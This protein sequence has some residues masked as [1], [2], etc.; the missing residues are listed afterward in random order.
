MNGM[1]LPWQVGCFFVLMMGV[2]G[3]QRTAFGT[4]CSM[5]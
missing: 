4:S 1:S 2:A 3:G 5:R